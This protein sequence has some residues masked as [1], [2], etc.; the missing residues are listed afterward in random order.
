MVREGFS[1]EGELEPVLKM[2]RNEGSRQDR[3]LFLVHDCYQ[4]VSPL[5]AEPLFAFS[6]VPGME[7]GL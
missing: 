5:R 4:N 3:E 2:E 7:E 6:S 1:E